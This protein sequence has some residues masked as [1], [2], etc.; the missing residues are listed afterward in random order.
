[1]EGP[2]GTRCVL[3]QQATATDLPGALQ[4]LLSFCTRHRRTASSSLSKNITSL[5]CGCACAVRLLIFRGYHASAYPILHAGAKR[6]SFFLRFTAAARLKI[7]LKCHTL[8]VS[9][10]K[11][12]AG[13][14]GSNPFSGS[15]GRA[16][17]GRRKGTCVLLGP[18]EA[19]NLHCKSSVGVHAEE[20]T[21]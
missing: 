6:S 17:V 18:R 20:R 4:L 21:V 8:T 3:L 15:H 16:A 13:G 5:D 12:L 19:C 9:Q 11:A 2:C 10:Y 14:P 1:M 7:C